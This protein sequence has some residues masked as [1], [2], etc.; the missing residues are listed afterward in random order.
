MLNSFKLF[1]SPQVLRSLFKFTYLSI[2]P[3]VLLTAIAPLPSAGPE[4]PA[5]HPAL[6]ELRKVLLNKCQE[7]FENDN[8]RDIAEV[9][10][11]VCALTLNPNPLILYI[12]SAFLLLLPLP[13]SS[14]SLTP[15]AEASALAAAAAAAAKVKS[16]SADQQALAAA[17]SEALGKRFAKAQTVK[18]LPVLLELDTEVVKKLIAVRAGSVVSSPSSFFFSLS[19]LAS[20]Y[21]E[22]NHSR[23][24]R[25]SL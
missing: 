2:Y 12:I 16:E 13:L 10:L 6:K 11:F 23:T 14:L 9:R 24:R 17:L 21:S 5:V 8:R 1:A 4:P 15:Q 20:V 25:S 22:T 3:K 19:L 7:E 18:I